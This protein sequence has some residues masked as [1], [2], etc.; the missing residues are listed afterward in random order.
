MKVFIKLFSEACFTVIFSACITKNLHLKPKNFKFETM[1]TDI[2]Q[3]SKFFT[4][5]T[6][7]DLVHL[8]SAYFYKNDEKLFFGPEKSLDCYWGQLRM[9][10]YVSASYKATN[11]VTIYFDK[12]TRNI[13]NITASIIKVFD[14]YNKQ[15]DSSSNYG[16]DI[17]TP[18]TLEVRK[19]KFIIEGTSCKAKINDQQSSK[20]INFKL[21]VTQNVWKFNCF[22]NN[23][24]VHSSMPL[25]GLI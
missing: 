10:S 23:I 11:D 12:Y 19:D 25:S 7:D 3:L 20:E 6:D 4:S 15:L 22:H 5:P 16:I 24:K 18:F 8:P 17:I 21:Y 9:L 1:C 2:K 14:P 13:T